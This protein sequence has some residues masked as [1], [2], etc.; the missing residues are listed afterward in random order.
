M[1]KVVM[2]TSVLGIVLMAFLHNRVTESY[3]ILWDCS[4]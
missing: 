1:V 4:T 3:N 2:L